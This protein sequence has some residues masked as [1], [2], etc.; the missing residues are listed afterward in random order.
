MES[1]AHD[2]EIS[3]YFHNGFWQP[4]DTC[5]TRPCSKTSGPA[6]RRRGKFGHDARFLARPA[7]LAHRPHRLQ[8][9]LAEHCGC[10][11]WAP[12]CHGLRTA[13][14]HHPSLFE[15][16]KVG[17]G[18]KSV[19]AD[20]RDL[21]ALRAQWPTPEPE[22]VIH[23]AAQPLVRLSYRTRWRPTATNVMGTVHLLEAVRRHPASRRG[24]RHHRQVLRKP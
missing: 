5:A 23:M 21:P 11:A 14:T 24:Q 16:A 12:S 22:V 17:D 7:R 15:T 6:A 4:M 10:R 8:G 13:T 18:M 3:A 19:I 1:L 9:Q 20:I 2:G